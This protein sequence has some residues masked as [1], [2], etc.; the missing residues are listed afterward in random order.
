MRYLLTGGGTRT[1]ARRGFARLQ[2]AMAAAGHPAPADWD[3][4]AGRPDQIFAS[5]QASS[6][7]W[8]RIDGPEVAHELVDAVSASRPGGRAWSRRDMVIID[9]VAGYFLG[10]GLSLPLPLA[11]QAAA[12]IAG[13][14]AAAGEVTRSRITAAI[15]AAYDRSCF[16]CSA[17][18]ADAITAQVTGQL[19]GIGV[20]VYD[21]RPARDALAVLA[22]LPPAPCLLHRGGPGSQR[23]DGPP[24]EYRTLTDAMTA[25]GHPAFGDW[26]VSP[27]EP[28]QI[29]VPGRP[30]HDGGTGWVIQAPGIARLYAEACPDDVRLRRRW[31]ADSSTIASTVTYAAARPGPAGLPLTSAARAAARLDA[32][33]ATGGLT[34]TGI[35]AVLLDTFSRTG[36]EPPLQAAGAIAARIAGQLASAGVAVSG[37]QDPPGRPAPPPRSSPPAAAPHPPGSERAQAGRRRSPLAWCLDEVFW[38]LTAPLDGLIRARGRTRRHRSGLRELIC[39]WIIPLGLPW[40]AAI[41]W[42]W[43]L[44]LPW[45]WQD[46]IAIALMGGAIRPWLPAGHTVPHPGPPGRPR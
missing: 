24:R 18:A 37:L 15:G 14:F 44:S 11:W 5:R 41:A 25:A 8:W 29:F 19:R 40:A 45:R 33:H 7:L 27:A 20:V 6:G 42:L 2:Q 9:A 28:G 39:C 34:D 32:Q 31:S 38:R 35:A 30:G 1:A 36:L 21:D 26:Q 23:Q 17:A 22:G 43:L 46:W 10:A 12:R 3:L 16:D 4:A 13:H